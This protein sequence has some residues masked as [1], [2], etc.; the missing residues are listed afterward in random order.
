MA[1]RV[2]NETGNSLKNIESFGK[3]MLIYNIL[4]NSKSELKFLGKNLQNV[5]VIERSITE[6]KKHNVT[7]ERLQNTIDNTEDKYLKSKLEDMRFN[8]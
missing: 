6:L 3:S 5:E 8:F 1:Y 7:E 4:D 2:I